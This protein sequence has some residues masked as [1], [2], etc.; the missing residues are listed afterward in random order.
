MAIVAMQQMALLCHSLNPA[1]HVCR[2]VDEMVGVS[3]RIVW[4][5]D[6][7]ELDAAGVEAGWDTTSDSLAAWLAGY[8]GADRLFLVKAAAIDQEASLAEL[9]KQGVVD[10]NFLRFASPD[11]YEITVINN[12]RFLSAS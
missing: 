11:R 6:W 4:A 7:S 3:D 2:C 5:P 10:A 12:A 1:F 9:Q 8:I